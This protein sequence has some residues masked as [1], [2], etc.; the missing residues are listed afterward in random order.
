MSKFK[1]FLQESPV[2]KTKEVFISDRFKDDLGKTALFVVKMISQ[3]ENE[4]YVRLNTKKRKFDQAAYTRKMV[5][6]CTVEPNFKDSEVC[7]YYGV[8][9]PLDVPAKMLTIGEYADLQ[10]AILEI[11]DIGNQDERQLEEAKNS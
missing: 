7:E 3:E 1:A 6:E 9:D 4:K 11:N 8:I 2:G 5:V 10:E